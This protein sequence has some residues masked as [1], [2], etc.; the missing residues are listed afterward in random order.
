MTRIG[1]GRPEPYETG[2]RVGS[3]HVI[4]GAPQRKRHRCRVPGWWATRAYGD[5]AVFR[6]ECGKKYVLDR[7]ATRSGFGIRA[8]MADRWPWIEHIDNLGPRPDPVPITAPL[9]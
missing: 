3:G 9:R 4:S 1:V 6:C 2:H 7:G 5:G 8:P